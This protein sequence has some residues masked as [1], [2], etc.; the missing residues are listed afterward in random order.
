MDKKEISMELLM[1]YDELVEY[2]QNKYGK[3][4]RA[5]FCTSSCK[6]KAPITRGNE[7][8]FVHHVKETEIDDLS[9]PE[10]AK[11]YPWEYQQPDNLCYCNYLEHLLLHCLI[12]KIRCD[13]NGVFVCD[14]VIH[15]LIPNINHIY[16]ENPVYT[17]KNQLWRNAA[18]EQ[19]WGNDKDYEAILEKWLTSIKKY[20]HNILTLEGLMALR[21][22]TVQYNSLMLYSAMM[23]PKELTPKQKAENEEYEK[24]KKIHDAPKFRRSDGK[25]F[26]DITAAASS[27]K[28]KSKK[29]KEAIEKGTQV[30]G[31]YWYEIK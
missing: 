15:H 26:K 21:T 9:V 22:S 19:I 18:K 2:L 31:F 11:E 8:L 10:R 25:E 5:Y 3:P 7:G 16:Q 29:I 12:N 14:G 20:S 27:V 1:G 24:W 30:G 28:V 6:S 17:A 4:A 23:R 13:R